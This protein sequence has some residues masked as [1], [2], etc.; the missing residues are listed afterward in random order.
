M[1]FYHQILK[2]VQQSSDLR[3]YLLKKISS[4]FD[5][6]FV[7]AF[8]T[9]FYS[10]RGIIRDEDVEMLQNLLLTRQNNSKILLIIDS[11]GGDPLAAE[12]FIKVLREYSEND[13]GVLIPHM[14]KSAA[15]LLL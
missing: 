12:R 14:A 1:N 7:V 10:E 4:F 9:N 13:Y 15:P 6:R 2:E 11:P 8:Y 3:K 5:S